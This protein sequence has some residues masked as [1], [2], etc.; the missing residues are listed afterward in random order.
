VTKT[1]EYRRALRTEADW[2]VYLMQHSGLPG[3]RANLELLQ[4]AADEGDEARFLRW[5]ELGPDR[6]PG[7][8]PAGFL[9]VCGVV[10]LGRLL[11]ESSSSSERARRDLLRLLRRSAADPRWR[12]RE[13]VAM[14]LQRWGDRDMGALLADMDEWSQGSRLE[15]RAA[16]AG[17]CEPRLLTRPEHVRRVLAILDSITSSVAGAQDRKSEEFRVLRQALG[18]CW[19]VAVVA[20]PDEGKAAM[21]RWLS[22][23]GADIAWIMKEN[24]K[25][26]RLMRMDPDWVAHWMAALQSKGHPGGLA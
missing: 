19:S 10:D 5:L 7:D 9:V 2:D 3:P 20:L 17:L 8:S 26:Q 11:A 14:A 16:A 12:V 24:L 21:E 4:A 6:A 13:G 1:E 15:Q 25:K 22:R 23:P 18:Y